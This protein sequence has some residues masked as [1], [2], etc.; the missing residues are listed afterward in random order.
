MPRSVSRWLLAGCALFT[1][2]LFTRAQAS[3]QWGA[4]E[5]QFV[6]DGPLPDLKPLVAKGDP[7][8][9]DAAVCAADGVPNE[10]LVVDPE[11]KGIA[12]I[13]VYL[14]KAPDKVHPDLAKS[15]E[16]EIV[17]D[18]KACR[19]LPHILFVRTDQ[20]VLLK[21]DDPIAHNTR[22][23]PFKNQSVNVIIS[24]QDRKGVP[25]Q[26]PQ[27]ETIPPFPVKCDI[28]AWMEAHWMIQDHPYVAISGKDG[29]FKIEKLP[30][31][32]HEFRVWQEKSG[33]VVADPIAAQGKLTV[34]IRDGE[35]VQFGT[36]KVPASTFS[37]P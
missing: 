16:K 13:V 32:A 11:T 18:Q 33:Y 9:R 5:G 17:F 4:I 12:N 1:A 19:F 21:S 6:L 34:T 31:G 10:S 3:A 7:S 27:A 2:T 25:V 22:I 8:A 30:A 28:H 24:P 37:K 15:A 35:S 14:R 23:I 20:T 29:K 26:M 36:I